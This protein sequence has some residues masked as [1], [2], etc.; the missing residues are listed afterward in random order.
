MTE[1]KQAILDG[2]ADGSIGNQLFAPL[3]AAELDALIKKCATDAGA[4]FE[5]EA[6]ARLAATKREDLAAF[7]RARSRLKGTPPR[8]AAL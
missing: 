8:G 5:S 6:V 2:I 3:S 4:P 1:T 7:M